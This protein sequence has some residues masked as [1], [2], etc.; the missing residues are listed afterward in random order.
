MEN[1]PDTELQ[2]NLS[3]SQFT[4][5]NGQVVL[6]NSKPWQQT[7]TF[8]LRVCMVNKLVCESVFCEQ[9]LIANAIK[10]END[11]Y[12]KAESRSE[13]F[14]LLGELT[15]KIQR[16]RDQDNV[17]EAQPTKDW[18]K[19]VKP[20][21]RDHMVQKIAL[22]FFPKATAEAIYFAKRVENNCYH[23][24][25]SRREYNHLLAGKVYMKRNV[26]GKEPEP[27]KAKLELD[28]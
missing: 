20:D 25:D 22:V 12:T 7:V 4:F 9:K 23:K 21:L 10:L 19:T 14:K 3:E 8:D 13:Y 15:Y 18:Q 28:G 24:A 17:A 26:E 2:P 5:P 11:I 27:K 16:R 6:D 1:S